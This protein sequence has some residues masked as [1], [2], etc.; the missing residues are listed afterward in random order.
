MGG[1]L[2]L[3]IR[4]LGPGVATVAMRLAL[5]LALSVLA[6]LLSLTLPPLVLLSRPFCSAIWKFQAFLRGAIRIEAEKSRFVASQWR[7]RFIRCG[8]TFSDVDNF[9]MRGLSGAA[10]LSERA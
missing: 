3:R 1:D 2:P 9:I 8:E 10:E 6:A 5:D 7:L 4:E